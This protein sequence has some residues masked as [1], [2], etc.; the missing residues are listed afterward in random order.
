MWG[1]IVV[2]ALAV[3][4]TVS[5]AYMANR[6]N[7]AVLEYRMKQLEDKVNRHNYVIERTF[8][9]EQHEAVTEEKLRVLNHRVGDLEQYHK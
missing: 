7:A 8:L 9:L 4:G 1:E 3:V 2:A 6:K 5:G